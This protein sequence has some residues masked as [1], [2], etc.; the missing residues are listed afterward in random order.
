M[1]SISI[2]NDTAL[3]SVLV[4]SIIRQN[5]KKTERRR[6]SSSIKRVVAVVS[7]FVSVGALVLPDRKTEGTERKTNRQESKA[8]QSKAQQKKAQK[9]TAKKEEER[10]PLVL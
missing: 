5:G 4:I 7:A 8:Q 3:V 9:N 1:I 10:K 6:R 2:N